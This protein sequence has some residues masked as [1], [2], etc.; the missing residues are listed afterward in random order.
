MGKK[1]KI[2]GDGITAK[3]VTVYDGDDIAPALTKGFRQFNEA[4]AD[5]ANPFE[6]RIREAERWAQSVLYAAGRPE[7][8]IVV[9]SDNPV[10]TV[11]GIPR[12]RTVVISPNTDAPERYAVDVLTHARIIR[13]Q[14][15]RGQAAEAARTAVNLGVMIG[16]MNM[17]WAWEDHALHGQA[18]RQRRRE[19]GRRNEGRKRTA[20]HEAWKAEAEKVR[21]DAPA[22]ADNRSEVARRVKRRLQLTEA[23]DTIKRRI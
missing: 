11:P 3:K 4:W 7:A 9:E 15:E 21:A 2:V 17:K 8:A 13:G 1:T 5:A 14:I 23:V 16:E 10:A 6:F 22:I 18:D 12:H 19:W 20:D